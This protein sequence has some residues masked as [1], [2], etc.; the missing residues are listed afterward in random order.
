M[1]CMLWPCNLTCLIPSVVLQS[2]K[3]SFKLPVVAQDL[4][5]ECLLVID[6][7]FCVL[8]S[9][10]DALDL[11][12][13]ICQRNGRRSAGYLQPAIPGGGSDL[14]QWINDSGSAESTT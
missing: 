9:E 4:D 8:P 6:N 3:H 11:F 10:F 14:I 12:E 1:F 7:L 5:R 2:A 13:L